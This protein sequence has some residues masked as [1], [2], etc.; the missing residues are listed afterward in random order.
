VLFLLDGI[1]AALLLFAL[2]EA[3][4]EDRLF[5]DIKNVVDAAAGPN[6]SPETVVVNAMHVTHEM[7]S[8]R[9]R[10]LGPKSFFDGWLIQSSTQDLMCGSMDCGSSSKVLARLLQCYGY[11]VRIGQMKAKGY[12]GAHIITE[13]GIGGRWVV[14]DPRYDLVFRRRDSSLAGFADL[15]QQWSVYSSQTPPGY[16]NDYR[17]EDIRY[18]RWNKVP[19][20]FPAIHGVLNLVFGKTRTAGLCLRTHFLRVYVVYFFLFLALLVLL[21]IYIYLGMRGRLPWQRAIDMASNRAVTID[22]KEKQRIS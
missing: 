22:L 14:A 5:N 20:I 17:Y 12:F 16:D 3:N 21:N 2:I 19:V 18:T 7:M 11:P 10:V 15:H 4:R 6:A 8:G 1:L 13:V 9:A